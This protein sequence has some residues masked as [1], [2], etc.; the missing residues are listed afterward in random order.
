M[1]DFGTGYSN[2]SYLADIHPDY[3]K[4]DGSL[5]KTI[6][7]NKRYYTIVKHVN[8]FAHDLGIKTIA[9][10]VHNKEV[11]DVLVELGIDGFQ[12]YY[13]EEPREVI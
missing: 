13:I 10:F 9:E 6:N 2:F 1:D 3:I 8:Y 5:I 12:G 7:K 11:Y 4:I